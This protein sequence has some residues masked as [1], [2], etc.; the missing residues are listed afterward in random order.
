MPSKK[1]TDIVIVGAGLMGS[2]VAMALSELAPKLSILAIDLDLEG[3]FSSSELNAGGVRATWNNPVN[4]AISRASIDYYEKIASEIGFRQNGYFWMFNSVVWPEEKRTLQQNP[5]LKDLG[6]Q[7]LTPDE[8]TKKYPFIDKT[9]DLGGATFSPKDGLLNPNLLKLH[10]RHRAKANGVQFADHFWVRDVEVLEKEGRILLQSWHFDNQLDQ[11]EIKTILSTDVSDLSS[12]MNPSKMPSMVE[13]SAKYLVNCS[14]A[15]ARKFAKLM[16]MD[17]PSRAL[18]RQVSVF[19]CRQVDI[20]HAGMFVD[21]SGVYFH[22]EAKN[23]LAGYATPDEPEGYNFEYDGEAFFQDHIWPSL[24]ERSSRFEN[25]KHVTGWAGLY[26]VSPDK[27]AI[28]GRVEPFSNV[29][30]CH[31]FSGRGA[32]QSYGAG[33]GLAELM[34]KGKYESIDLSMLTSTRFLKGLSVHEGL[35]I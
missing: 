20:T 24:Y 19:E 17:C 35:L 15:W 3:V 18:R 10:Y 8:I 31:S 5:F 7:Y 2:S 6:I 4:A 21:P 30:E 9:Q 32:M 12:K 25:L 26:E 23:I 27:S 16:R 22:S 1:E 29:F 14:G 13:I 33:L 11:D 28:I 34:I